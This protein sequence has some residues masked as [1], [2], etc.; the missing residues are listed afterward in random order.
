MLPFGFAAKA[1]LAPRPGLRPPAPLPT[2][3]SPLLLLLLLVLL[4]L[5]AQ[6]GAALSLNT[7]SNTIFTEG[8]AGVSATGAGTSVAP[9]AGKSIANVTFALDGGALSLLGVCD[10]GVDMPALG[11]SSPPT[12]AAM[13]SAC[14]LASPSAGLGNLTLGASL[15]GPAAQLAADGTWYLGPDLGAPSYVAL[16]ATAVADLYAS[17]LAQTFTLQVHPCTCMCAALMLAHFLRL[18]TFHENK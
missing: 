11:P 2:P 14:G 4:G 10:V 13:L 7:N 18:L 9:A 12:A 3:P 1:G 15:R 6:P 16:S 5:A 8:S 17:Q